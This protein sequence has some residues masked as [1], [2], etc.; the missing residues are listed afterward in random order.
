TARPTTNANVSRRHLLVPQRCS[1]L[2]A[3]L[4]GVVCSREFHG[5]PMAVAVAGRIVF[6]MAWIL[7]GLDTH[8][9]LSLGPARKI[10]SRGSVHAWTRRVWHDSSSARIEHHAAGMVHHDLP[11]RVFTVCRAALAP[12]RTTHRVCKTVWHP[13]AHHV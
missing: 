12:A 10:C 3:R 9:R 13:T 8:D 5:E 4:P 1:N 11:G 6:V 7:F 2:I